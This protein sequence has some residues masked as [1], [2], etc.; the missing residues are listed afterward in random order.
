MKSYK[1][2][3]SHPKWWAFVDYAKMILAMVCGMAF[4]LFVVGYFLIA[5][6]KFAFAA[7][8]VAGWSFVLL[9]IPWTRRNKKRTH[10]LDYI[11]PNS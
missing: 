2:R 7:L 1:V 3:W 9:I 4:F 5:E 11:P 6:D 10:T 8:K